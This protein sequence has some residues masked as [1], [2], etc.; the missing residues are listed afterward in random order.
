MSEKVLLV[1]ESGDY[2]TTEAGDYIELYGYPEYSLYVDWNGD[3]AYSLGDALALAADIRAG[4]CPGLSLAA[5]SGQDDAVF[6]ASLS[7]AETEYLGRAPD[8]LN[9]SAAVSYTPRTLPTT[10]P[11]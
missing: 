4:N 7:R 2:L 3:G 8:D 11:V 10:H 9:L 6:L 1:T 5:A